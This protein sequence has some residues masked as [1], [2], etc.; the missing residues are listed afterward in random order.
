MT[1]LADRWGGVEDPLE[2]IFPGL[3]PGIL[4]KNPASCPGT[5]RIPKE[6]PGISIN[7]E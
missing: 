4:P 5:Q 1:T 6:S 3:F 7:L 2:R